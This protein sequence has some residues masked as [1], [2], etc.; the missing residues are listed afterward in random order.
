MKQAYQLFILISTFLFS[1]LAWSEVSVTDDLGNT[2]T[3]AKPAERV[4]T[5]A[6]F[7]TE[8]VYTV[9]AQDKLVATVEYSDY[10]PEANQLPRIG[11]YQSV[12][13]ERVLNYQP[14]LILS[15]DSANNRSQLKQFEKLGIAVYRSEPKGLETIAT[16]LERI[17]ILTGQQQQAAK[18]AS[19]FR[20]RW[21][22]LRRTYQQRPALSVFYQVWHS[23]IYTVNGE[24][25]ISKVMSI[26]GLNNVFATAPILAPKVSKES[27]IKH[28]PQMIIASGMAKAEPQWLEMWQAW[29][30]LAAVKANNLFFVH[31]DLIQ[32]HATRVLDAAQIICEQS[33]QARKNLNYN[34]KFKKGDQTH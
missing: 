3:L 17:G 5:F 33:E 8:L 11:N 29:P 9:G 4:V 32:R 30:G 24:H 23:P 2:V 22:Q 28:D 31:P 27:V 15:W 6:P 21:Q 20:Q 10:P 34:G 1:G 12:R 25:L 19:A 26:C 16:N 7:L 13:V 14:D 18:Q